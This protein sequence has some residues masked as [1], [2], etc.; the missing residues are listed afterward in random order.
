MPKR[1]KQHQ[2]GSKAV[3]KFVAFIPSEWVV[4][5]ISQDDYGIDLEVEIFENETATGLKFNVQSKSTKSKLEEKWKQE[6]FKV[7]TLNYFEAQQYP[8]LLIK[9][10]EYKDFFLFRWAHDKNKKGISEYT[11]KFTVHFDLERRLTTTCLPLLVQDTKNYITLKQKSLRPPFYFN[12]ILD[13][14][15]SQSNLDLALKEYQKEHSLF[16]IKREIDFVGTVQLSKKS[17]LISLGGGSATFSTDLEGLEHTNYKKILSKVNMGIACLFSSVG[18]SIFSAQLFVD[19]YIESED[20]VNN[21]ILGNLLK[22]LFLCNRHE[23]LKIIF[24]KF[25]IDQRKYPACMLFL[26]KL[27]RNYRKSD[28]KQFNLVESLL[29]INLENAID[30]A[31]FGHIAASLYSLG[32][33]YGSSGHGLKGLKYYNQAR[34]IDFSYQYRAYFWS[35]I[36]AEMYNKNKYLWA[37]RYY[38]YALKFSEEED[39]RPKLADC[40]L[41]KGEIDKALLQYKYYQKSHGKKTAY[42]LL[43]HH[44]LTEIKERFSIRNGH[45]LTDDAINLLNIGSQT[46]ENYIKAIKFD[47]LCDL[48]WFNLGISLSETEPEDALWCFLWSAFLN[49]MDSAAWFN[50]FLIAFNLSKS[51]SLRNLIPIILENAFYT[52]GPDFLAFAFSS[53]DCN[54][55]I[56][57]KEDLKQLLINFYDHLAHSKPGFLIR[58]NDE[59]GVQKIIS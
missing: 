43:K 28:E 5:H 41:Q 14:C 10:I 15:Y 22:D 46:T 9:Y 21:E 37:Q 12:F 1:P 53:I 42:W 52:N 2:I 32:N 4:R 13:N 40:F 56:I 20:F 6:Q 45:R 8:V 44:C 30:I 57:L 17:L 49:N 26:M 54:Q 24:K 7:S 36:A 27:M 58:I 39:L 33:F 18:M 55:S 59:S 50:S 38:Q 23:D 29:E 3:N 51:A 31:D 19:N 48:G 34:K 35:E 16:L 47:F 11:K 25:V